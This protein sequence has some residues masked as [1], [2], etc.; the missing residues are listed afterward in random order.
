MRWGFNHMQS[1]EGGSVYLR[2]STKP[3]AQLDRLIED[4]LKE[5]IISGAYWRRRPTSGSKGA[6]VYMGVIAPEAEAAQTQLSIAEDAP[7]LLAVT[8]PDR[9]YSDWLLRGNDSYISGLL[10]ELKPEASLV[11][12]LDGHPATL[13]WL[14]GVRGHRNKPLGV[15]DFG[16]CGNL[17]GLYAEHQIDT[18][19]ICKAYRNFNGLN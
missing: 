16:Q 5:G 14:S 1:D 15:Y 7:G 17:P 4:E 11:T 6:I 12:V 18:V 19:S 13:S 2:L 8:S 9:L 3:L 10:A